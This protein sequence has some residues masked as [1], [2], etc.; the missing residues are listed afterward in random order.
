[1]GFKVCFEESL[2]N[3]RHIEDIFRLL[4]IAAKPECICICIEVTFVE[5]E[6]VQDTVSRTSS[7]I[8]S[9]HPSIISVIES[10]FSTEM[11]FLGA[12]KM[13]SLW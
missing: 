13:F 2:R 1:M 4:K 12:E 3:L 11:Y 8:S 10:R 6:K 9:R 7:D 5:F